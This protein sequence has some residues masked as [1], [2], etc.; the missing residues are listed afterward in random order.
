[1]PN[2]KASYPTGVS[3]RTRNTPTETYFFVLN[4]AN[5][6]AEIS[7]D[8]PNLKDAF[9]GEPATVQITLE[10]FGS[11]VFQKPLMDAQTP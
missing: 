10:A 4:Y 6:A 7:L 1:V 11:R 2:A 5:T 8:E 9:T 3:I